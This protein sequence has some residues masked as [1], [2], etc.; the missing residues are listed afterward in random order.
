[1]HD[2]V[3][4]YAEVF[5][6]HDIQYD[7]PEIQQQLDENDLLEIIDKYDGVIAGDDEFSARVF[8]S[9]EQLDVV[10]KWGIG[11]DNIDQEAADA[12]G[13]TVHNTPGAFSAEVADVVIGYVIMLTRQLHEI[14][15]EVRRGT[16]YT[17]QGVSLREKTMGIIGVGNIGSAVARRTAALE[18][19]L[20]GHDVVPIDEKLKSETGIQSV[21]LE[22]L[23]KQSDVVSLNCPLTEET[24]GLIGEE[25]LDAIGPEGYLINTSR[26]ELVQE[27]EL[28]TALENDQ[29]AGAAL[30][31]FKTEPLS[32][33]SP[34]TDIESV[35]L[36]SHNAQNTKEAV[37]A[38]HDRAVELLLNSF[39]IE[40][41]VSDRH[42]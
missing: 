39:D 4:S 36:G 29:I 24:R 33:D 38:V 30:D 20:L 6:E 17:P 25:E 10:V 8:E 28:I 41:A 31:V 27:R 18:M 12:H 32:K 19:N 3:E 26:G 16:W 2:D 23:L 1:M 7:V 37:W 13:V 9:A 14:D 11:M 40:G 15:R 34:L 22:S 35:I 21:G 5:A 42:I